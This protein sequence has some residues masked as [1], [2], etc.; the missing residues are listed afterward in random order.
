MVIGKTT[1]SLATRRRIHGHDSPLH[2][3]ATFDG[4]VRAGARTDPRRHAAHQPPADRVRLRRFA[5]LRR[6]GQGRAVLGRRRQRVHRLGQRHRG[7]HPRLLPIPV[8][9]EAVREQISRGTVYSINHELEIELAEELCRPIPC[10]EMVRYAKCGGE[11]CAIAVRIARG[12][13]GRDKV[14]FCGYHGWHDWYL[15]AN[16][17]RGGQPQRAPVSRHRADRRAARRW[18]ARPSRSPTATSPRWANCSTTI[19]AKWPPSSW[20]RCGRSCRR[21]AIWRRLPSSAREHGAVLI[22]DEVSAGFRFST[23]GVQEYLGVTPDMAVFAKSISNGYPMAA[24]VGRRDVMEPAAQMFISST[25]WSDTIGLRAA[26]TT[27]REAR[28]RDV[29]NRLWQFGAELKGRLNAVAQEVGL[30]VQCQGVDVHPQ[31]HFAVADP[32]LNQYVTTLYIQEMA[33]RG[34]SRLCVVLFERCAGRSRAGADV[35]GCARGVSAS[36]AKL[37]T[38]TPSSRNWSARCS[39]MPSGV[40]YVEVQGERQSMFTIEDQG[41]IFDA[42][43]QP[44]AA[45]ESPISLRCACSVRARFCAVARTAPASMRL[46]A[47]SDCAVDGWRQDVGIAARRSLRRELAGVPGSLAA[48]ELV[49]AAPGRLLLFATWFDRS[50]PDRPL[51]DPVTEGILKSK[52]LL[53][54]SADDGQTWS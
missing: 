2:S 32:Q 9:D 30:A 44:P 11:A 26:L 47:P 25:Y 29:A 46:P 54:V 52:L 36:F 7:D 13:T 5:R 51:F 22:F 1:S 53:S 20:S 19:A 24:V 23:G 17:G 50:E 4:A 45:G 15:A 40:S 31:L 35:P 18:P 39:K 16:L 10:A 33:K 38:P 49:E 42:A 48:A 21:R 12:A 28:R 27:I 34:L 8:V 3:R 37:W 41:L 14:L 43:R 6:A